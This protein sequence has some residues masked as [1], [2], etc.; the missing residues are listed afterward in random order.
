MNGI[1]ISD[2]SFSDCYN[3]HSLNLDIHPNYIGKL[4]FDINS[5]TSSY[6]PDFTIIYGGTI[7]DWE[8][9]EKYK[10][11]ETELWKQGE[12][13]EVVAVDGKRQTY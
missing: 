4:A 11:S 1:K 7:E 9:I 6:G 10:E 3:L 5:T 12:K 2:Y 8:N 13:I